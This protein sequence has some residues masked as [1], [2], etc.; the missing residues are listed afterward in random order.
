MSVNPRHI[1]HNMAQLPALMEQRE[2]Q[3]TQRGSRQQQQHSINSSNNNSENDMP[4]TDHRTSSNSRPQKQRTINYNKIE[5]FHQVGTF[6][7]TVYCNRVLWVFC[8]VSGLLNLFMVLFTATQMINFSIFCREDTKFSL[9]L[10]C[11]FYML[12]YLYAMV[13]ICRSRNVHPLADF[14]Q[15]VFGFTASNDTGAGEGRVEE[16]TF[17][18]YLYWA[19]L[20]L[21]AMWAI[22]AP[23]RCS[24]NRSVHAELSCWHSSDPCARGVMAGFMAAVMQFILYFCV[25]VFGIFGRYYFD[26]LAASKFDAVMA[27]LMETTRRD[28][29]DEDTTE[30]LPP[31]K[32]NNT[33]SAVA[34]QAQEQYGEAPATPHTGEYHTA[35]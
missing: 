10:A 8:I 9:S 7:R 15:V 33:A 25:L 31:R 23:W 27:S 14:R 4:P 35:V 11:I 26:T 12:H 32:Q 19:V 34:A 22:G 3:L 28:G 2:S 17:K 20:G 30:M 1:T 16:K 21:H 18:S 13:L 24:E 5:Q 29:D 6:Q